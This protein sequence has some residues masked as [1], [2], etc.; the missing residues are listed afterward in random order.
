VQED[1]LS[2]YKLEQNMRSNQL[3]E[4]LHLK[5]YHRFSKPQ[6]SPEQY[7]RRSPYQYLGGDSGM[8]NLLSIENLGMM[9]RKR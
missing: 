9:N 4:A 8:E 1:P 7:Q 5:K 2:P 6:K 3:S